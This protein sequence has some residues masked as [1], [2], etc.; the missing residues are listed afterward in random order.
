MQSTLS[1]LKDSIIELCRQDSAIFT[2][3]VFGYVNAPF[4]TM[5]HRWMDSNKTGLILAYR[6]SGK[7]LAWN[8]PI[9]ILRD[10]SWKEIKAFEALQGDYVWGWNE[11]KHQIVLTKIT[12][13]FSND[14]K[15]V[16]TVKTSSGKEV[17][18]SYNHPFL[19]KRGWIIAEKLKVDDIVF[20]IKN[21][22]TLDKSKEDEVAKEK[23][24]S[25]TYVDDRLTIGIT[26]QHHTIVLNGIITHNSEQ[27]MGRIL[28]EIGK[29]PN[30]RIKIAT[31][32]GDLAKSLLS[33]IT[34][35]ITQNEKFKEIFPIIKPDRSGEWSST[36]IR[37][38]RSIQS[39]DATIAVSGVLTSKTGGRCDLLILDDI[40]GQR[41]ALIIPKLR[42]VVKDTIFSNWMPM[43]DG[44]EAR[45]WCIGTPWHIEDVVSH[46]RNDSNII[47][48]PEVKVGPN[49]E[50]PWPEK[51]PPEYFKE[52]L[53]KYLRIA[54]NRGYRLVPISSDETWINRDTLLAQRDF[55]L[56]VDEVANNKDFP[57]FMGIDLAHRSGNSHCPTVLFTIA[58]TPNNKKIPCSI[59]TSH[60]ASPL[61]IARLIINTANELNPSM[62][63][64]ENVGAQD[65]LLDI[66]KTLG[67][68][69]HKIEG[70]FTGSQKMDLQVGVPSLLAE[71]EAGKWVFPYKDGGTHEITCTC[72]MCSWLGELSD[73]PN[74]SSDKMMASWLSLQGLR[75]LKGDTGMGNFSIWSWKS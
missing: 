26:T 73:F 46:F 14:V 1:T 31:E 42:S 74:G 58:L 64:V 13:V 62:I 41:S 5:W 7:C 32:S 72:N 57:K 50:S 29:N 37:V 44:P 61:N 38:E 6:G 53:K 40:V 39:K 52:I 54:F 49:F 69:N 75:K 17:L 36:K 30:I 18:V 16:F 19:T 71:I 34:A 68:N 11:E 33:K 63:F 10:G 56:S 28:W 51:H 22:F 70:Y 2:Q 21:Y 35:T 20:V 3:Y 8:T 25:V 15:P 55:N 65:W 59:K 66:M 48:A 45:W 4:H 12:K 67:P 43:L 24:E 60:D 47:K 9:N 27:M 23:I